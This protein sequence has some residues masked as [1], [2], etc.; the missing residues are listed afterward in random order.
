M[1]LF[2][3][4]EGQP[5]EI[6]SFHKKTKQKKQELPVYESQFASELQISIPVELGI[7]DGDV[8]YVGPK[9]SCIKLV[10]MLLKPELPKRYVQE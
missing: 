2:F 5:S 6:K 3:W 7:V 1:S 8:I 4:L 9:G 10:L